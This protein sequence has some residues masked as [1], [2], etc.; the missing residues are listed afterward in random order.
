VMTVRMTYVA[1]PFSAL[2]RTLIGSIKTL[3]LHYLYQSDIYIYIYMYIHTY[4]HN[5]LRAEHS[6]GRERSIMTSLRGRISNTFRRSPKE[7][8]SLYIDNTKVEKMHICNTQRSKYWNHCIGVLVTQLMK[9]VLKRD[10]KFSQR[11]WWRCRVSGMWRCVRC[12]VSDVSGGWRAVV[13]A[14]MNLGVP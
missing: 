13:N 5:T 10:L 3:V 14:V 6:C 11:C 2:L 12:V 9:R 8:V 7:V 4:I 1:P